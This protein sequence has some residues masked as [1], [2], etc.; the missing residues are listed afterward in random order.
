MA[1]T[2]S[3]L[4]CGPCSATL[5]PSDALE[6][7]QHGPQRTR[8]STFNEE[9]RGGMTTG[10]SGRAWCAQRETGATGRKPTPILASQRVAIARLGAHHLCCTDPHTIHGLVLGD[11][12]GAVS[13]QLPA[14]ACSMTAWSLCKNEPQCVPHQQMRSMLRSR[15][16]PCARDMGDKHSGL[17]KSH[18]TCGMT[19]PGMK[20][21]CRWEVLW[22][23]SRMRFIQ[24]EHQGAEEVR[25]K[26]PCCRIPKGIRLLAN[27][28]I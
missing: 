5:S 17:S 10:L 14:H 23:A 13:S 19:K 1:G 22:T 8:V 3:S 16:I 12:P 2:G 11:G 6:S 18:P 20:P 25:P 9:G 26:N 15:R 24:S 27:W 28:W 7:C 21:S 4:S